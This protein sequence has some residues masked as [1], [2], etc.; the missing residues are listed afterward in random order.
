[1]RDIS[2]F[3]HNRYRHI[4]TTSVW[5]SLDMIWNFF[6]IQQLLF[7]KLTKPTC[8]NRV[9]ENTKPMHNK[10]RDRELC[11]QV[12][13]WSYSSNFVPHLRHSWH[14]TIFPVNLDV[15]PKHC[16]LEIYFKLTPAAEDRHKY[17]KKKSLSEIV[18]LSLDTHRFWPVI[19]IWSQFNTRITF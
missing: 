8:S 5:L 15:K 17:V 6:E 3:T 7:P 2:P 9:C 14:S 10:W 11:D 1:V 4:H 18:S 13:G 12:W 16:I 19:C